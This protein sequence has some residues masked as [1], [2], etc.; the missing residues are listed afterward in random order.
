MSDKLQLVVTFLTVR[1]EISS[2]A[3]LS[4]DKLKHIEHSFDRT[5][6]AAVEKSVEK[7]GVNSLKFLMGLRF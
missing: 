4:H 6:T 7:F 2:A 5:S 3:Y 1:V